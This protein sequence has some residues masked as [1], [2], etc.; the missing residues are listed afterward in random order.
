MCMCCVCIG[1]RYT[2]GPL[3]VVCFNTYVLLSKNIRVKRSED[4]IDKYGGVKLPMCESG[5]RRRC[6]LIY[7]KK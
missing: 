3:I 1:T 5:E 6:S 2:I 4:I 7:Q